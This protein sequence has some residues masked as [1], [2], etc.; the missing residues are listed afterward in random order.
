MGPIRSLTSFDMIKVRPRFALRGTALV[1]LLGALLLTHCSPHYPRRNQAG[2][3][4]GGNC[5]GGAQSSSG[6]E[7]TAGELGAEGGAQAAGGTPTE[8][9]SGAAGVGPC[10]G[11]ACGD[12]GSLGEGGSAN[13]GAPQG[14]FSGGAAQGGFSGGAGPTEPF[15]LGVDISSVPESLDQGA[16]FADTDGTVK[17]V[18]EVFK[19]HGFN[20]VRLRAFVEPANLYGYANPNGDEAFRKPEPYCDTEHTLEFGK[21]VKDSGMGLL[22]DLHYSDNWADPGKQI[23]PERWRGVTSIDE[24]GANVKGYTREL[25]QKLVEGGARPD[26]IQIGNEI[27]PGML[28]QVPTQDPKPDQWGN[29]NKMTNLVNG[30]AGNWANL[31]SLLKQGI[32]GVREVDPTIKVMLHIENTSR[33]SAVVS[34]VNNARSR[35]V[36]FDILGLSCYTTWQGPPETWASAFRAVSD[37]FP[38]LGLVIA[39]YGLERRPANDVLHDLPG[40]KGMGTFLWEPTQNGVWGSSMFTYEGG[41]FR[42]N[43]EDF[44]VF[45]A[46]RADYGLAPP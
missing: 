40:G 4:Q 10:S 2:A 20:Y 21:L 15:I 33:P 39:E 1:G 43:A 12:G 28:I 23:I 6:G 11:R 34:W 24:L 13:G 38:D 45:D 16:V 32:E 27:T 18:L 5:D 31:A 46:I 35:G 29:L 14:G 9:G 26:M 42:A 22:V 36:S 17:P 41:A 8:P 25:V 19:A 3:G 30:S 37:A 7:S 44:A